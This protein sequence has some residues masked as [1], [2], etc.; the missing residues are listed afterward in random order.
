MELVTALQS[1][2]LKEWFYQLCTPVHGVQ[3]WDFPL[4]RCH[5]FKLAE[6]QL[7]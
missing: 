3:S 1:V 4:W 5:S 7:S 2:R 6:A